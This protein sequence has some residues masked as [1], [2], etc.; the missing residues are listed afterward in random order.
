M[1]QFRWKEHKKVGQRVLAILGTRGCT[2]IQPLILP[3]Y[4]HKGLRSQE[5]WDM[6]SSPFGCQIHIVVPPIQVVLGLAGTNIKIMYPMF[7]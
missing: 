6:I 4:L 3:C 2:T 5:G 1:I 7:L